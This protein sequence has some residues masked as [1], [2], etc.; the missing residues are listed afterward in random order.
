MNTKSNMVRI[1]IVED[2]PIIGEDLAAYMSEFGHIPV[3]VASNADEALKLLKETS[4]DLILLDVG[5]EGE[6]DGIQLAS[7]IR[8]KYEMPY[9]FLTAL[10]DNKTIER[11]KSVRPEAYLVKPIDEHSL[12]T[13]IE[14]ALYNFHHKTELPSQGE[15]D[16][17]SFN[18]DGYFF[19]KV[20]QGLLKIQLQDILFFEAYDN[21]SWVYTSDQKHLIGLTLKNIEAKLPPKPFIRAHR[22][23]IVNIQKIDRLDEISLFIGEHKVPIGKT[24]RPDIMKHIR[25]L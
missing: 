2:N 10:Y 14:V 18:E 15:Q 6:I 9:I 19:I 7:L 3:G 22:S 24:F 17:G 5:L 8:D 21:Y 12:K 23:Y 13:T 25:L 16:H 11:I 1:L 20:K 4:V